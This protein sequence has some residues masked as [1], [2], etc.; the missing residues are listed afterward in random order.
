[1]VVMGRVTAPFGIKGWVR[2]YALT[3]HPGNLR[4][5]PVWWLGAESE[6]R[7]MR[8]ATAKV[9]ATSLVAKLVGVDNR[10][11]AAAL[12]G[13]DIAV[14]REQLPATAGQE[15][16]WA[17]LIGLRVLNREQHTLGQ[18]IRI[19]ETGA[20]DVLVIA[21]ERERLVPF[22]ADVIQGVDLR[23]GVINVDWDVDY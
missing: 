16:Y 12:K 22:I 13:S 5:Y 3:A 23:A 7:E 10:E 19:V 4:D 15:F 21:G 17:D 18:V 14:P 8:V 20:N 2:I 1:M 6:W 9:H 11:A